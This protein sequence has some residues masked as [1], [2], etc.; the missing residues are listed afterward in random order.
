VRLDLA[1]PLLTLYGAGLVPSAGDWLDPPSPAM[2][3]LA[4]ELLERLG[5]ASAEALTPLGRRALGL[6][7]SPRLARV[8]L[9]G[10]RLGITDKACLAAALLGERDI[11]SGTSGFGGPELAGTDGD[12]DLLIELY[13]A[14]RE[15]RFHE[16]A[17]RRLGLHPGRVASVRQS[18]QQIRR[19]LSSRRGPDDEYQGEEQRSLSLAL[20]AGF[21][22]RV[23]RRRQ[24]GGRDVI[25]ATGHVAQLDEQSAV[26]RH[27][28]LLA[29]DAEDRAHA[30]A[31]LQRGEKRAPRHGIRVRL[32][33]PLE[34]EWLLDHAADQISENEELVWDESRERVNLSSQLRWGAV[35]LDQSERAAPPSEAASAL[36]ERAAL[37]QQANLFSQKDDLDGLLARCA[38][39][40]ESGG[41]F[42]RIASYEPRELIRLVCRDR[43]SLAELRDVD[44]KELVLGEL[45]PAE[46]SR[47][48]RDAP[49]QVV[50]AAGR[51]VRVN[52]ERGKAPW[53]ESRLQ[54]F[55]GML[56]GP[57]VGATPLTLHLLAPNKRAVQVTG[58]L[59]GFWER[60]YPSIRKELSRRY[61]RHAWPEDGRKPPEKKPGSR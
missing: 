59:P 23:A 60:H 49:E 54:D 52:Y 1:E 35:V 46:R 24:P 4:R 33:E 45:S 61:P 9:E 44:V 18:H 28:L 58:D 8:V 39:L 20:L 21:P 36:L 34:A 13:Q 11:R 48:E 15:E 3:S 25:L 6:P 14:A 51:R 40:A 47:L 55:F 22:D 31:S 37:A 32:A 43:T 30:P 41:A 7:L 57:R 50:L 42:A 56:T 5:L 53:I 29:V 38:L 16:G 19:D 10:E 12:V 26:R 27:N 2:L 17:L